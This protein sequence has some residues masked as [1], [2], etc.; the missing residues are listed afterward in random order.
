MGGM[1]LF[2]LKLL[3]SVFGCLLLLRAYMRFM[4]APANDP[5]FSFSISLT[6][7]A[8]KQAATFIKRQRNIEW[9]AIFVCYLVAVIYQFCHWMFG[10][11]N[12]GFWPFFIGSAV[13]VAYWAIEL[14]MW[15]ALL[16]CIFSWVNPNGSVYTVLSYLCYPYLAPLRKVIP[17]WRNIDFSA[18]V[19]FILANFVLALLA[20]LT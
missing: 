16:F 9:P 2:S 5:L 4:C 1:F 11:G 20:P 3:C 19:F 12:F 14:A 15:I 6:D 18:I 7:W 10:P 17:V 13:L 8:V